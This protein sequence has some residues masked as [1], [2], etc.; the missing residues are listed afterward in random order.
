MQVV[1]DWKTGRP[2]IIAHRGASGQAPENTMAAFRLA[3]QKGADAIELDAKLSADGVIVIH[4]DATLDRTTSGYGPLAKRTW[5]ELSI[6]DAGSKFSKKYAGEAIPTLRQVLEEL[7]NTL[8]VNI[9]LTNYMKPWDALPE[10]AA[11]LVEELGMQA[12]VLFSSFNPVALWRVKRLA[13]GIP[14]GLL[15]L[16]QEPVWIRKLLQRVIKHE[17][18]HPHEKMV[19]GNIIAGEH[20]K[21]RQVN[22]WTVNDRQRMQA[23]LAQNVDG[24]ITDYPH[25]A[26]EVIGESRKGQ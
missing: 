10:K 24:L 11:D 7:G 18:L 5:R 14:V 3:A 6:L 4:H 21:G 8:L 22:V 1:S 25:V 23:L 15:L 12:R 16:P 20:A 13:P 26:A 17:A 19:E 2:L 9:E